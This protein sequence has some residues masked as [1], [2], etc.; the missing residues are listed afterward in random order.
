MLT[1]PRAHELMSV[2]TNEEGVAL[3]E[4]EL[5]PHHPLV[6]QAVRQVRQTFGP[7]YTLIGYWRQ[8]LARLAPTADEQLASGDVLILL[9]LLPAA[10]GSA[11]A[12]RPRVTVSGEPPG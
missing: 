7:N 12:S 1:K 2:L 11:P 5:G 10:A 9:E 3:H 4:V 6:G 8:D